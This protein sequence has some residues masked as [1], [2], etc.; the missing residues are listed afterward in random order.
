MTITFRKSRDQHGDPRT[1]TYDI[2][3]GGEFVGTVR[4]GYRHTYGREWTARAVLPDGRG[5][6]VSSWDRRQEAAEMLISRIKKERAALDDL[7]A[8]AA[9]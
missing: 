9:R 2:Y 8:E 7:A 1:D 3:E 4:G 6:K 5:I